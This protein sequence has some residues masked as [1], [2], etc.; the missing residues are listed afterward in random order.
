MA[1]GRKQ[2]EE[3][4]K[5]LSEIGKKN[6]NRFWLGKKRPEIAGK[7]HWAFGKNRKDITGKNHYLWKGNKVGYWGVHHW[8]ERWKGKPKKCDNCGTEKAK[9]YEW[10]NVDHKYKRVLEDYIRM[11]TKCHR[12][13]DYAM[14]K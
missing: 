12:K 10:A 5:K 7:N 13:Y 11:C 9:K 2:T 8:I 4:K 1:K 6:P 14:K 3:T